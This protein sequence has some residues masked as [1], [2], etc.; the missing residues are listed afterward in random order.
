[1]HFVSGGA[2]NGKANWVKQHYRLLE[3]NEKEHRWISAYQAMPLPEDL[4]KYSVQTIVLEGLEEWILSLSKTRT[5]DEV[6]GEFKKILQEWLSWAKEANHELII[7]GVDMSKGV[8]PAD[9]TLRKWRDVTGFIYQDMVK[10]CRVFHYV[11]YG[12]A[13]Q[14]K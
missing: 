12:I 10:H 7:V 8:V 6:R 14:L 3:D 2:Y 9:A 5:I 1:M 11:W 4:S 13:Q